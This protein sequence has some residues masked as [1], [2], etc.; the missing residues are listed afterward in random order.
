M[1]PFFF[2]CL[3]ARAVAIIRVVPLPLIPMATAPLLQRF[4][5]DELARAPA[6]I[7]QVR[8]AASAQLQRAGAPGDAPAD[9][10]ARREAAQALQ[11]QPARFAAHCV[12]E[13]RALAHADLAATSPAL[14]GKPAGAGIEGLALMDESLVESDIEL[15]RAAMLIDSAVEWEQRELQAYTSALRGDTHVGTDSN[16]LR[17]ALV[18]RA[19]W[20]ATG[21]LDLPPAARLQALRAA[22][23]AMGAPLKLAYATAARRIEAQGVEASQYRT[24]LLA[25][26][27]PLD[28][29]PG[30]APRP[31]EGAARPGALR[32]LL[33]RMPGHGAGPAADDDGRFE[34]ALARLGAA[35]RRTGAP[36]GTQPKTPPVPPVPSTRQGSPAAASAADPRVAELLS[37]LFEALRSDAALS[38]A[39]Q[40]AIARLQ[41]SATQVALRDPALLDA[42]DHPTWRL[43]DR[44]ASACQEAAAAGPARLAAAAAACD[45]VADEIA[46]HAAPDAA[47]HRQALARLEARLAEQLRQA[48]QAAQGA[49]TA[50]QRTDGRRRIQAQVQARLEEQFVRSPVGAATRRYLLGP[51]TQG[52]AETIQRAGPDGEA[53]AAST[54]TVDDLLWSL[55][56]PAHP[57]SR[58]RLVKMLPGLLARLRASMAQHALTPSQQQAVL[59]ELEAS[60]SATL[61]PRA[62][63]APAA[64]P[65]TA[66]ETPEDIVRRLREEVVDEA[67]PRR[68]FGDSVLDLS[69]LDTVPAEL[70]PNDRTAHADA[71]ADAD[72]ADAPPR[73]GATA[74]AAL[75]P[76]GA[77][78]LLLH[79]RWLDAQLL[80]RSDGGDLLLFIDASG[81]THALTQRAFERLR[82]EGLARVAAPDSAVHRA[83]K[84]LLSAPTL[85]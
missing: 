15:S 12:D 57:A 56:P 81:A 75:A 27:S 2:H 33:A 70:L 37:R 7:E 26:A 5:D 14:A 41:G 28:A 45:G 53:T 65:P 32:G 39:A 3:A 16:P 76:G 77:A 59:D 10:A 82:A 19:L 42:Q 74:A 54:R 23:A 68:E 48:Q 25:P 79:G 61:W 40:A 31:A 64:A 85:A 83:I 72:T 67:P 60:H 6:L 49:I 58:A 36:S 69:M 1:R 4:V 29:A 24:V 52:L 43:I 50:L 44:C 47:L 8:A 55:H 62:G 71:D 34:Q 78:R 11:R 13:L 51:W 20:Q 35:A 38:A 80:W 73:R 46:Q 84:R 63:A 66:A 18:A 17:P 30:A 21:A 22:A 9:V